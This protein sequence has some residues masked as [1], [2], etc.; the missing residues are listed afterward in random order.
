MNQINVSSDDLLNYSKQVTSYKNEINT[1]FKEIQ[2]KM[3]YIET[4]WQSPASRSFME[5]FQNLNPA[6]VSYLNTLSR[7]SAFL[8][9]TAT[10]YQENE[11]TLSSSYK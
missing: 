3:Y 6:M 7:F 9:E 10:L 1:V 2:A 8:Q 11:V 4:I 5:K